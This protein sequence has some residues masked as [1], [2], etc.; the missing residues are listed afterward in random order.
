M[1][2]FYPQFM[3]SF[4]LVLLIFLAIFVRL[5]QDYAQQFEYSA[6]QSS[7]TSSKSSSKLVF[8]SPRLDQF[9]TVYSAANQESAQQAS[10]Q[11]FTFSSSHW[12]GNGA[13][14]PGSE[15]GLLSLEM[16]LWQDQQKMGHRVC[17][18]LW[19]MDGWGTPSHTTQAQRGVRL[20]C[21]RLG[22]L[23]CGWF[24]IIQQTF[25]KALSGTRT[26]AKACACKRPP[27]CQGK[28]QR[29]ERERRKGQREAAGADLPIPSRFQRVCSLVIYGCFSVHSNDYSFN[30]SL[31]IRQCLKLESYCREAGVDRGFA[32]GLS[33]SIG[34]AGR[35]QAL[36]RENGKRVWKER[37][38]K[39][40]SSIHVPWQGQ[41]SFRG[42]YR[43]EKG[44]SFTVDENTWPMVSRFGSS[45]PRSI[46]STKPFLQK[47]PAKQEAR[48]H[49]RAGSSS[50]WVT[51]P[52]GLQHR[53]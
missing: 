39:P 44:A 40:P 51:Q 53:H 5:L 41:G 48:L 11:G 50:S 9:R 46:G 2:A 19:A 49:P 43:Q 17:S 38:Q 26:K 8:V 13:R 12:R 7:K 6:A 15:S 24:K 18:V 42:S 36:S 22:R 35:H 29:E 47:K 27:S 10:Q 33:R 4:L 25:T 37:H 23:G 3:C 14:L 32:Q 28:G 21:V 52:V 1:H 16:P 20:V 31:C 30:Q 34:Y 45:S